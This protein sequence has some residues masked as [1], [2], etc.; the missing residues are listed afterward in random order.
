[1]S[2]QRSSTADKNIVDRSKPHRNSDVARAVR[3]TRDR[4]SQQSGNPDFDRELLK[5]HARA[6]VS[7]VTA[8]P[9]LVVAIAAAGLFAGMGVEILVWALLAVTCYTALALIARRID[10]TEAADVKPAQ[11]R[12][13]FLLAHFASGLGWA[14]GYVGTGVTSTNLAGR[15]LADLVLG[16]DTDLVRLPWVGHRAKKWEPEPLRWLA[17]NAIYAAYRT[18]DRF[19]ASGSGSGTAWPAHVAGFLAGR[20]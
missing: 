13:D 6:M 15:T 17:V 7:G 2:L 3:K 10:R 9:L 12:R 1:M 4:L 11:A 8:I 14:G 16:R 18:A 19:E 20:S 5:L